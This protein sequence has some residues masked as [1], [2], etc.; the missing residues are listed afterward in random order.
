MSCGSRPDATRPGQ[1]HAVVDAVRGSWS[2]YQVVT[3]APSIAP[4]VARQLG[5]GRA[6]RVSRGSRC[7][8][9]VRSPASRVRREPARSGAR[10]QPGVPVPQGAVRSRR[11]RHGSSPST[12]SRSQP[13]SA[14]GASDDWTTLAVAN[15]L[16]GRDAEAT[17]R[18]VRRGRA[19]AQPGR[20]LQ[21]GGRRARQ[22][23]G[24]R[25]RA[26]CRDD[27]AHPRTGPR[28]RVALLCDARAVRDRKRVSY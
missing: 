19:V 9:R 20:E 7:S 4:G 22:S 27:G 2:N 16:T 8:A 3:P 28:S 26:G 17:Q 6:P 12:R 18:A 11:S 23:W 21:G 1:D 10:R 15:A 5:G 24:S 13:R 25:R 14:P